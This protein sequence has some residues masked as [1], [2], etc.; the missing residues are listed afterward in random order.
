MSHRDAAT[1]GYEALE[2]SSTYVTKVGGD[3]AGKLGMNASNAL[4]RLRRGKRQIWAF[5]AMRSVDAQYSPLSDP[6]TLDQE[7]GKAGPGF[8]TTSHLIA[9][10]QLLRKGDRSSLLHAENIV[11]TIGA[12]LRRLLDAEIGEDHHLE[13]NEQVA[14]LL[15]SCIAMYLDGED[16]PGSLLNKIR[17]WSD[18]L[19][20]FQAGVDWVMHSDDEYTSV[21]GIGERL[22]QELYAIYFQAR[23]M[24]TANVGIEHAFQNIYR[25]LDR[26][27]GAS[28]V[29]NHMR[30]L[31]QKKIT[32]ALQ[33]GM[34]AVTGGYLP[35]LGNQ[36]GYSD[37]TGALL[38]DATH[39]EYPDTIYLV[40][41]E[42]PLMSADPKKI[43]EAKPIQRMTHFLAREL[44]GDVRGAKGGALHSAAL[45]T[46]SRK[47]IS[48]V[49]MN[50]EMPPTAANTT[51]IQD[52]STEPNGVEI[53]AGKNVPFALQI[54]DS[55]LIG[56]PEFEVDMMQW[57]HAHGAAIQHIATSEGTVSFTFHE[58]S[59]S[60]TL[61]SE[62]ME[63]L[64]D[65]H[66]ISSPDVVKIQKDVSL[67]YCLGNNMNRPGQ[68]S[69]ATTA[70]EFAGVDIHFITQGLNESVMTFLI[71]AED[72][73]RAVQ[74][75]HDIF[76]SIDDTD[77]R[78]IQERFRAEILQAIQLSHSP[79]Q[80]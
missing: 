54:S 16:R 1:N 13:N 29:V 69:K 23:G 52:F 55:S 67:I 63:H 27:N 31:L 73:E 64:R 53:I 76:I 78:R 3:N 51:L 47:G 58:G 4:E 46:L 8:N 37:K 15:H 14:A 7:T 80:R 60:Q 71:D 28:D 41:K 12:F 66:K 57:F 74:M 25:N 38:A 75:L 45:D 59:Y 17:R 35:I 33:K 43:P 30:T 65:T 20:V 26:G 56:N 9:V 49:V 39:N 6:C 11:K 21:T 5:S 72:S 68:A 36:R 19:A 24:P 61:Q 22:A 50:P 79:L 2:A 10:A 70:L 40:E 34:I 77:Y 62:L 32:V 44:F 48:I 18:P 42:F